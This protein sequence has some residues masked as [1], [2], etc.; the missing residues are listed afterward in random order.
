MKKV[1]FIEEDGNF[2]YIG[3]TTISEDTPEEVKD[4]LVEIDMSD[5]DFDK[6]QNFACIPTL[7]NGIFSIQESE[8]F[9][10][11]YI[12]QRIQEY[13]SFLDFIDAQVKKSSTDPVIV[14]RWESQEKE[15]ISAC[16]AVKEKY[17]KPIS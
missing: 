14:S 12:A 15:Y 2:R 4:R 8:Q 7:Q 1:L 11:R 5:E 6:V 10:N 17:P 3:K 16:L 9:K 13:P